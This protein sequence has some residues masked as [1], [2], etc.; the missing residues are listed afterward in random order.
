MMLDEIRF[1]AENGFVI[2]LAN[3]EFA[4]DNELLAAPNAQRV[5]LHITGVH[6]ASSWVAGV[7]QDGV[8]QPFRLCIDQ[9][10]PISMTLKTHGKIIQR[11]WRVFESFI[12]GNL[13]VVEVIAPASFFNFNPEQYLSEYRL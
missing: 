12:D 10:P 7:V 3:I 13:S 6:E 4:S 2:R 11:E 9:V 5:A 8:L 1:M